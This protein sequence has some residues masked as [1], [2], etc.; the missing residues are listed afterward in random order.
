MPALCGQARTGRMLGLALALVLLVPVVAAADAEK[1]TRDFLNAVKTAD[2]ERAKRLYDPRY[3]SIAAAGL[4]ALF[5]Y[6][7]GYQPNL[8]FLVGHPFSL[9][10]VTITGLIHSEWYTLD[11]VRGNNVTARIRFDGESG[12]FLLPS[13]IAFGRSMGF[14]DFMNFVKH[15]ESGRFAELTLRFRPSVAPGTITPT[16]APQMVKAPPP[17]VARDGSQRPAMVMPQPTFEGGLMGARPRDPGPVLLPSGDALTPDQLA[18]LLPRLAAIDVMV[19]AMQRGRF[20]SW[21]VE[22]ITFTNVL[23]VSHGAQIPLR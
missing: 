20:A 23:L 21:K 14:A 2:V 9:E 16:Q 13:P 18:A 22:H 11:G 10:S 4:D 12:P 1:L 5:R 17:P 8:A 19:T 15:P 6:E 3:A 7:S